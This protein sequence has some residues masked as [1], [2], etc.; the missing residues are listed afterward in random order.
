MRLITWK[1]NGRFVVYAV[2]IAVLLVVVYKNFDNTIH[3]DPAYAVAI[4]ILNHDPGVKR[5]VGTLKTVKLESGSSKGSAESGKAAYRF[6]VSGD[7][8]DASVFI[9]L[10]NAKGVWSQ[11][12]VAIQSVRK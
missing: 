4:Y 8:G 1:S 9:T 5:A 12:N 10:I 11:Q 6:Q 2:I 3:Q 7:K